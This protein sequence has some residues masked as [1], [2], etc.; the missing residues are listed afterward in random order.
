MVNRK[1]LTDVHFAQNC[2]IARALTRRYAVALMLVAALSTAAW[3]SLRL[4]ITEQQSTAAIVNV[5]GRQ[6]MLSQRTALFANLLA[7]TPPPGR[8]AIRSQLQEAVDLM[9]R[10]HRGLTRGDPAMGLP[11]SHSPK[12][13]AMYFDAGG[14]VDAQVA[15]YIQAVRQLLQLSD[16][17]LTAD[18][19]LLLQITRTA[20]TRL[21]AALDAMVKQYQAE[22][23]ANVRRVET[24]ETALWLLT[25]ALLALEAGLIFQPFVRHI[26]R[27]V[28]KLQQAT[29]ELQLHRDHLEELVRQRTEE[30][31]SKSAELAE[32]MEKFR[33]ISSAAQDAI[34]IIGK[35]AEVVHWN[36]AAEQLFGYS[37]AEALGRNLHELIV[38]APMRDLARAG[39]QKFEQTGQG[40]MIGKTIQASSL[41]KGGDEFP[42]ELS[43]SAVK[44]QNSWHALSII[45]DVT[46]RKGIEDT[47]RRSEEQ[48]RFVLE[49][50]EL[51]F[52]DWNIRTGEVLRNSRWAEML[53]YSHDE[54]RHTTQQWTD[55][56]HPDDREQAWQSILDVIEGRSPA[57][58]L[59]YRM[60]H[61]D[62]SIR[63]ILDQAKVM[64]RD[65]AGKPIRMSG[66]HSDITE[67]KRLEAELT[68]QARTDHLTGVS[69]R[70]YFMEQAE[71]ELASALRY[72]NPLAM[73]MMDIDFFKQVNDIHGHKAGDAVLKKL[74]DVCR[75]TLREADIIGR[76]GGEE[77][78]VLLPQTDKGNAI[79]AA[80][81]LKEALGKA[82][83]PLDGAMP[84]SFTVSIGVAALSAGDGGVDALLNRADQALYRA[85]HSGRNRVC[86]AAGESGPRF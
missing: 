12:V 74:A 62:G 36:R 25:L 49:G 39:Y 3:F 24:T 23:E 72:R 69:S 50:A 79:D 59:E 71:Q 42:I 27:V 32:S 43:I 14:G 78:A 16:E 33:L 34:V 7:M 51:G 11:A 80:E 5:S 65:A 29:G 54:I 70:G 81:R 46:K 47:L 30:L 21:V 22:G 13:H 2:A 4:V 73:L 68:R 8:P 48:L 35:D 83:V 41:R 20:P 45:R 86:V 76:L 37:E 38:P 31:Q 6:R 52:W 26:N 67:R 17:V 84:L 64:Q 40:I 58:K 28:G 56:V 75:E 66:T 55:F 18:N 1:L 77:F 82:R 44:L 53:G 60:L 63:W 15:A 9:E 19:P 57:H 85:K 61:K 10:S